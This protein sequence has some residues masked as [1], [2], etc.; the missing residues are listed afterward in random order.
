MGGEIVSC[1]P[2]IVNNSY[3]YKISN[4]C[5]NFELKLNCFCKINLR[6]TWNKIFPNQICSQLNSW[7]L[8]LLKTHRNNKS[9]P[10]QE[11]INLHI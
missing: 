11:I 2:G 1:S 8:N 3:S 9:K 6:N 5:V 4:I 10:K 7:K